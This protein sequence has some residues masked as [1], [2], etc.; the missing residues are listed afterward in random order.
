MMDIT[1]FVVSHREEALLIGD[2]NTY[3]AQLS[4]RLHT[5]RKRLGQTTP[6]GRK[7]TSK[8]SVTAEDVG[9]NPEY[10]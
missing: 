2:Y 4:R 1:K 7:Y 6:K 3:R 5:V 10:L 8:T 9:K